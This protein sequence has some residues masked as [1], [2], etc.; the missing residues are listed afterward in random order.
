MR[1]DQ[2]AQ[3]CGELEV[4]YRT[5]NSADRPPE[6]L[7]WAEVSDVLPTRDPERRLEPRFAPVSAYGPSENEAVSGALELADL[8]ILEARAVTLERHG[9]RLRAQIAPSRAESRTSGT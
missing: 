9:E 4:T 1:S 6:K 7:V 5:T 8:A 3:R 2:I